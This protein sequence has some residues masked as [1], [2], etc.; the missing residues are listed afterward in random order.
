MTS[1]ELQ[2][3][4]EYRSFFTQQ[5]VHVQHRPLKNCRPQKRLFRNFWKPHLTMKEGGKLIYI[6]VMVV[7]LVKLGSLAGQ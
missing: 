3:N 7:I 6:S 1:K 2:C 5:N 4:Q